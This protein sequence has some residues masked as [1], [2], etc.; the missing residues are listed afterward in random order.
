[1]TIDS[2]SV[3]R[4][5][6]TAPST[7]TFSPGRTRIRSPIW[8]MSSGTSSSVPSALMRRPV[9]GARSSSALIAPEVCSLARSSR[10]CPSSTSTV[11]TAAASKYTATV[12]SM[13]RKA[14]GK[15]PG[16]SVATTL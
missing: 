15:T 9:F 7:G 1:M 11:I 5:S 8:T 6:W 3:D 13:P 4:P 10:T 12:P 16:A 2:S 14:S